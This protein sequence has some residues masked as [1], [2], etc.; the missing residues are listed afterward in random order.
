MDQTTT[1]SKPRSQ[2]HTD[3]FHSPMTRGE[4][5]LTTVLP[6]GGGRR[7]PH[8][9]TEGAHGW[10]GSRA[11]EDRARVEGKTEEAEMKVKQRSRKKK[12]FEKDENRLTDKLQLRSS[13]TS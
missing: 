10:K 6:E 1:E 4:P 9:E 5:C 3:L 2:E 11:G 7:S 12:K 8:L 13:G